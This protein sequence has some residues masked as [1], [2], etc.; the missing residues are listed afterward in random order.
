MRRGVRSG[1]LRYRINIESFT[2]SNNAVTNEPEQTWS[3]AYSGVPA[4][5]L[6]SGSGENYEANQQVAK[7]RTRWM[8]RNVYTVNETM[9]IVYE[10]ETFY[11]SG[12]DRRGVEGY[13]ILTVERRDNE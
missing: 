5:R 3:T 4:K 9:R 7:E 12:I 2:T 11:I 6:Q 8:I 13:L 10:G 1:E